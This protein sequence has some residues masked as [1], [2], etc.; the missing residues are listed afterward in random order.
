MVRTITL[1]KIGDS[2]GAIIPKDVASRYQFAPSDEVFA[3]ET[4][5]GILLTPFDPAML[6][7]LETYAELAKENRAAMAALAKR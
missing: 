1:K 7:A 2:I 4:P 5:T 3:V 6:A